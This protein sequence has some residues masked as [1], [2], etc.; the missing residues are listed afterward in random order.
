MIADG[1]ILLVTK[2]TIQTK[3]RNDA[4]EAMSNNQASKEVLSCRIYCCMLMPL[5]V[6]YHRTNDTV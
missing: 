3:T 1:Y 6:L 4:L 5:Y 2:E